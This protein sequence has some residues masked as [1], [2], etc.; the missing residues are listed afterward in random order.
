MVTYPTKM[1]PQSECH[2][3]RSLH[4]F[5][6]LFLIYINDLPSNISSTFSACSLSA[7]DTAILVRADNLEELIQRSC[8]MQSSVGDWFKT[9][10]LL[11]NDSKTEK[12]TFSLRLDEDN[13]E[14]V[15]FPGVYLSWDLGWDSHILNTCAKLAKN[16]YCE[17]YPTEYRRRF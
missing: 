7:D 2:I 17:I 9:N 15:C 13:Q 6:F 10:R 4:P 3:E 12:L 14:P 11:M 5:P 16:V 1:L 8:A